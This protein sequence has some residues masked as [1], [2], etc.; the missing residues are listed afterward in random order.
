M[1]LTKYE[2][3]LRSLKNQ[4]EHCPGNTVSRVIQSLILTKTLLE[5]SSESWAD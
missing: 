2:A 3:T 4:I 1:Y 5:N